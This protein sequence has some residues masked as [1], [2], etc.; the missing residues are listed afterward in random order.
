MLFSVIVSATQSSRKGLLMNVHSHLRLS[1]FLFATCFAIVANALGQSVPDS[2]LILINGKIITVDSH[3]SIAQAIAIH[4]GKITAVGAN[5]EIRAHAPK[6]AQVVDL[7]GR[8][9]T[10]GL[11]DTHCHFDTTDE[12]YAIQLSN[13][14]SVAEA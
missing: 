14:K 13:I 7:H 9:A 8:T 12:L 5:E 11:I 3:D 1:V 6:T 10:P 2:D 4:N